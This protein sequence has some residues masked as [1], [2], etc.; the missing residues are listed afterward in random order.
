[1]T[2]TT[3]TN[4]CLSRN[5]RMTSG[6]PMGF[7]GPTPVVTGRRMRIVQA[8]TRFF[9]LIGVAAGRIQLNRLISTMFARSL[10]KSFVCKKQA[11][12]CSRL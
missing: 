3:N 6:D 11:R 4:S 2:S 12:Q 9:R 10:G 8:R 1:M 7:G 5:G